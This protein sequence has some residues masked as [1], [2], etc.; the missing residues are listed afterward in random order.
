MGNNF[1]VTVILKLIPILLGRGQIPVSQTR[2]RI[3][4]IPTHKREPQERE[5]CGILYQ[6]RWS[7]PILP[8]NV[9]PLLFRPAFLIPQSLLILFIKYEESVCETLKSASYKVGSV[10][11][12]VELFVV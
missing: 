6:M 4:F 11:S 5:E 12:G 9:T 3:P 8:Q 1:P 7:S 2:R 10:G